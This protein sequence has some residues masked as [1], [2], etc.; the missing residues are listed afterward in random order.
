M[1]AVW[2]FWSRPHRLYYHRLWRSDRAHLLCWALSVAEA[3][4]HFEEACLIADDAG[5]ELLVE[6]LGLPF[7]HV[8]TDLE[9]LNREAAD[10][11]WWV[12]GKLSAYAAQEK[13]FV[14][15]D[16]DVILWKPLPARLLNAPLLA[17]NPEHFDFE[18]QSL[19]RPDNFMAAI[20]VLGG[21]LPPAWRRYAEA[22]R[23]GAVC[24]GILGG[25]DVDFLGRYSRTAIA[26]IRDPRNQPVWERIGAVRDNIL[27]EQYFLAALLEAEGQPQ[28]IE[29]LFPSSTDAF[30]PRQAERAGF[31]HLIG[32]AK[33]DPEIADRLE[34][35]VRATHPE[36]YERCVEVAHEGESA[37][38]PQPV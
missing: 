18:D 11:L 35:R 6:R 30:D 7:T 9:G 17:Q 31:T 1:R 13:P 4:R 14:H 15:L 28:R 23:N 24:C 20:G 29:H 16:A 36:L 37:A 12:L 34:A 8:S 32:D 26:I 5:A 33:A 3:A 25:A 22:Q 38:A 27:V 19:Y 2:S 21:W 10:P